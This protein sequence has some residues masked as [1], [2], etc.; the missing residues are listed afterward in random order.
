[1]KNEATDAFYV[2]NASTL[3]HYVLLKQQQ[4]M[5]FAEAWR[6]DFTKQSSLLNFRDTKHQELEVFKHISLSLH[7]SLNVLRTCQTEE[8][9]IK[10]AHC[11]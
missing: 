1:M 5:V 11:Q 4:M 10:F 9:L 3:W 2:M 6:N 7:L 8:T